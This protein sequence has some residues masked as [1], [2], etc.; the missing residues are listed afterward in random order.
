MFPWI[1]ALFGIFILSCGST[2]VLAVVTL[3]KPIYRFDGLLKA[4]TALASLGT[5]IL[6]FRLL[7]HI[8]LI[9]SPEQLRVEIQERQRSELEIRRLNEQLERRVAERTEELEHANQRLIESELQMRSILDGTSVLI[10]VKD[11]E[12]R[13][14]FV[15][16]AFTQRLGLSREAVIGH[17]ADALFPPDLAS[18]YKENDLL[19]LTEGRTEFEEVVRNEKGRTVYLSSKFPLLNSEET[20]HGVCGLSTEITESKLAQEG[21]V[22]LNQELRD[23]EER[24]RKIAELVPDMLWS[25]EVHGQMRFISRRFQHYS[26]IG[27]RDLVASGWERVVHPID[28]A[29]MK[30]QFAEASAAKTAMELEVRLRRRDGAY[31]WFMSRTTPVCD[32]SGAIDYWLGSFNDIDEMKRAEQALRRSNEELEQFA[33]AAAH[34]LQEP[35]RNVSISLGMLRLQIKRRLGP[36]ESEWIEESIKSSRRMQAMVQDLLQ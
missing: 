20:P 23:S 11:L 24:F 31:R 12:G 16:Q 7:P 8:L 26:G 5:A 17:T 29:E 15:N 22:R 1:F 3:W 13:F 18:R 2:H 6:L 10:F 19:A 9:P 27:E 34:D 4:V 30:K 25:G 32:E 36:S 21:L 14:A 33:Y 35:L 28:V